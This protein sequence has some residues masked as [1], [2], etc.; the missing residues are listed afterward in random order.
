MSGDNAHKSHAQ[1]K[2]EKRAAALRDN[3]K[4]RKALIKEKSQQD[5]QDKNDDAKS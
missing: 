4:K 5:N 3:L 2:A 1:V